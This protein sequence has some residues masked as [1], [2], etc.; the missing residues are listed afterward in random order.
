MVQI[1]RRFFF[2]KI[3]A[4]RVIQE[5]DVNLYDFLHLLFLLSQSL[6]FPFL[7]STNAASV[8]REPAFS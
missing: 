7:W 1:F 4:V 8:N 5:K 2:K 3:V 6:A